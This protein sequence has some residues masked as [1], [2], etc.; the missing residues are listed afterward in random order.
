IRTTPSNRTGALASSPMTTLR[1]ARLAEV[2][3]ARPERLVPLSTSAEI[4]PRGTGRASPGGHGGAAATSSGRGDWVGMLTGAGRSP[5]QIAPAASPITSSP[6]ISEPKM[7]VWRCC[8]CR[9]RV[10]RA[11]WARLASIELTAEPY[12]TT[13]RHCLHP[14][15]GSQFEHPGVQNIALLQCCTERSVQTIFQVQVAPPGHHVGEQVA[16]EGGVL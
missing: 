7:T 16:V 2:P 14:G 13:G 3:A 12:L 11:S 8:R 5:A 15:R 9:R 6:A 1:S 10:S 4:S